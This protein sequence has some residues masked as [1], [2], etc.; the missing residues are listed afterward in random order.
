VHPPGRR[1]Q[2]ASSFQ[3]YLDLGLTAAEQD[4]AA[5]S[6]QQHLIS[7]AKRV[8]QVAADNAQP[9]R[10]VRFTTL[11]LRSGAAG[12]AVTSHGIGGLALLHRGCRLQG[13][14]PN[15]SLARSGEEYAASLPE[16]ALVNGW[17]F[18]TPAAQPPELDP[19][20]SLSLSVCCL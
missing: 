15:A 13:L 20:W 5:L 12:P 7:S 8:R 6:P 2:Q 4:T 11:Q 3:R 14:A 19:V 17:A 1:L 16:E 18:S 10:H 9:V